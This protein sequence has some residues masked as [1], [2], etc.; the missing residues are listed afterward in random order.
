MGAHELNALGERFMAK[1]HPDD[2]KR[3]KASRLQGTH[4]EL[5]EGKGPPFH[6]DMRHCDT[7]E[8]HRPAVCSHAG[9]Q[10]H[11]RRL[12]LSREE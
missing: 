2:G 1:Y 8:L 12:L 4:Q 6:M 11:V 7:E 10:G 5:T 9:R 3:A